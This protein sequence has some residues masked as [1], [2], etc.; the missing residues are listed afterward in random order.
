MTH[1]LSVELQAVRQ[2]ATFGCTNEGPL[3]TPILSDGFYASKDDAL[4]DAR[5]RT[6][7]E[8][9]D[10]YLDR[11]TAEAVKKG[12]EASIDTLHEARFRVLQLPV[13]LLRGCAL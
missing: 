4:W 2:C 7:V 9:I 5:C 1:A 8:W 6:D 13:W 11:Y 10:K 3:S 12:D